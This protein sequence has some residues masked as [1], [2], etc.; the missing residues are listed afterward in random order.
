[1]PLLQNILRCYKPQDVYNADELVMFYNLMPD[2][3]LAVKGDKC[4]VKRKDAV[5]VLLTTASAEDPHDPPPVDA[6]SHPGPSTEP[7]VDPFMER[8]PGPS[9]APSSAPLTFTRPC[10]EL[11]IAADD[12]ITV[13]GTLDD[14]DIIREQQESSDEEGEMVTQ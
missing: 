5:H 1:M 9:T 14:A 8:Q 2:H 12:D 3:T 11:H 6:N 13:W 4:K 10:D 7:Q